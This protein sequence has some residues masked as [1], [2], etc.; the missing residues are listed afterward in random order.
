[1]SLTLSSTQKEYCSNSSPFNI[2]FRLSRYRNAICSFE[3]CLIH[4]FAPQYIRKI[5]QRVTRHGLTSDEIDIMNETRDL[6][7][8]HAD[9]VQGDPNV[10]VDSNSWTRKADHATGG[11]S[12][13]SRAPQQQSSSRG[14]FYGLS[15]WSLK[16]SS[17]SKQTER[18][19]SPSSSSRSTQSAARGSAMPPTQGLAAA[20]TVT[21]SSGDGMLFTTSVMSSASSVRSSS[22]GDAETLL[23]QALGDV[24]SEGSMNDTGL[25]SVESG[26][27][28]SDAENIDSEGDDI[29]ESE[30]SSWSEGRIWLRAEVGN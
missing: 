16:N 29:D 15:F 1:M 30:V 7:E 3:T 28:G 6:E 14:P 10:V 2:L 26:R 9:H 20:T 4:V 25:S 21:K 5:A 27:V 19:L 23:S 24:R 13:L 18:S 22:M 11:D 12:S 8:S 17:S